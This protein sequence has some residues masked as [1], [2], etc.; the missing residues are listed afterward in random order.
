MPGL[1]RQRS[2]S[3]RT[4]RS[5]TCACSNSL[6][7]LAE[8]PLTSAI[9]RL[10]PPA[11]DPNLSLSLSSTGNI[12]MMVGYLFLV[13][14]R[15]VSTMRPISGMDRNL[16]PGRVGPCCR[17]EHG[18]VAR[19]QTLE[20]GGNRR[21]RLEVVRHR[22]V[23]NTGLMAG[24]TFLWSPGRGCP[25]PRRRSCPPPREDGAH[26]VALLRASTN[27]SAEP[28]TTSVLRARPEKVLS[29]T[30]ITT[31]ISAM[32]SAPEVTGTTR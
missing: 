31:L 8:V 14:D 12:W 6:S 3:Q 16:R 15:G 27:A 24:S 25:P 5:T 29:P 21:P 23:S 19:H 10:L 18:L 17:R 26:P 22:R 28:S 1:H 2:R 9:G 20:A 32:A 13:G 7:V 11:H 30:R 4:I